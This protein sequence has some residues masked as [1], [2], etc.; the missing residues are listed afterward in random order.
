MKSRV[1]GVCAVVAVLAMMSGSIHATADSERVIQAVTDPASGV[2]VRI[3]RATTGDL[4]IGVRDDGVSI[5]KEASRERLVTIVET[6]TERV[7]LTTDAKGLRW[8][9]ANGALSVQWAQPDGLAVIQ[10]AAA[11]SPAVKA[12]IA[13]LGRFSVK[14]E[15]PVGHVL[16]TMRSALQTAAGD[17]AGRIALTDS[18][19]QNQRALHAVP[20]VFV[21]STNKCWDEYAIDAA[22][23]WDDFEDCVNSCSWWNYLGKDACMFFYEMRSIA[24]FAGLE[25]CVAKGSSS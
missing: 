21:P 4:I 20:V 23:I 5:R 1:L 10:Q 19:R 15:S 6:K 11:A 22:R 17:V 13:M 12:A 9:N 7:S 14:P 16:I 2:S 8:E 24:T 3:A 18:A 25:V